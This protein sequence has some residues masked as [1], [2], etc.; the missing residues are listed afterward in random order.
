[1]TYDKNMLVVAKR[2][3]LKEEKAR[4]EYIKYIQSLLKDQKV[5]GISEPDL[6]HFRRTR[7]LGGI[8]PPNEFPREAGCCWHNLD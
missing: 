1:M 7:R 5:N 2:E 8:Y 4:I 3:A 6:S